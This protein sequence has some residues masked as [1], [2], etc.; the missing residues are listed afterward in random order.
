MRGELVSVFDSAANIKTDDNHLLVITKNTVRSPI[1]LNVLQQGDN[2][3]FKQYIKF[4]SAIWGDGIRLI[5]EDKHDEH[6]DD[7]PLL[8]I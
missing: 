2:Q 7:D 5:V 4:G 3:S 8:S 6:G 1:S